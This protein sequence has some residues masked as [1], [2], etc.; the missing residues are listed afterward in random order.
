M[1]VVWR[2]RLSEVTDTSSW[3]YMRRNIYDAAE[4]ILEKTPAKHWD[5]FEENE[6]AI[7]EIIAKKNHI[8]KLML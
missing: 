2:Q 1:Q 3:L 5:W 8:T 6:D 7:N 4:E